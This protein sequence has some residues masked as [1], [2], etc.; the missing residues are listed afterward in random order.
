MSFQRIKAGD[1]KALMEQ[2]NLSIADIR[3]AMS[4]QAGHIQG[5]QRVDN[6]NL[7][8]FMAA[9]PKNQP[10]LVCCYHGNSSQG[11]AQFFASQGYDEVYS[12]DGGAEMWKM[13][14]PDL[15]EHS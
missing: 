4:F 6:D 13:A 1:A 5:A 14:F 7:A 15:T 8:E 12:L 10:L 11:A 3:D 9:T 2:G